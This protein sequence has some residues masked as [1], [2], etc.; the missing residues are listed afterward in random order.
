MPSRS[1]H[2]LDTL[3]LIICFIFAYYIPF[4]LFIFAY[5][6]LGPLHYLTEIPWLHSNKYFSNKGSSGWWLWLLA[7]AI[8]IAIVTGIPRLG[9]AISFIAYGSAIAFTCVERKRAQI[10]IVLLSISSAPILCMSEPVL[11]FFGLYL[12]T[13]VHVFFFTFLFMFRGWL[14]APSPAALV[15]PLLLLLLGASYFVNVPSA[16][17]YQISSDL[18]HRANILGD[19]HIRLANMITG[20]TRNWDNI[21]A[22]MRFVS[23]AYT[24]H[25]MNWFL[26]TGVVGWHKVGKERLI[27]ACALYAVA[28]LLYLMDFGVG[29]KILLFLSMAHVYLEFP[30]NLKTIISISDDLP[31]L[32]CGGPKIASKQASRVA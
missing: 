19:L 18:L 16:I 29:I 20:S 13:I 1:P 11:F 7:G 6:G 8:T 10:C 21:V 9:P 28:L 5:A 32:W 2:A 12:T 26:K 27:I 3:L 14:R 15:P 25:Y 24:Y 17:G 30:L 22:A 4:E 23:F 31:K